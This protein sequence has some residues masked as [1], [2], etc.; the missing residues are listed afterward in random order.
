MYVNNLVFWKT[1]LQAVAV[2]G[3]GAIVRVMTDRKM[4]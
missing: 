2:G 4:I 1:L 3:I